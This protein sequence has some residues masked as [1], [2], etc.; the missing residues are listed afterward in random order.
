MK[1]VIVV[2]SSGAGKTHFSKRLSAALGI[3]LVHIDRVYWGPDWTEPSED[4]WKTTLAGLLARESWIIDGN[5]T[6][7]LDMRLAASDTVI[8]LDIRRTL[9]VWRVIRRTLRFYRRRRPDMAD[10]CAE[11]FDWPFLLFI[12]NYTKKTKPKIIAR[13]EAHREST[14]LIHLKSPSDVRRFL[15][16]IESGSRSIPAYVLS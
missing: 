6:G 9:C 16:D 1:K 15:Q 14:T 8:F 2:G 13:I 5:Y 10:G 4:E 3:E 12:W 11:R 7:T